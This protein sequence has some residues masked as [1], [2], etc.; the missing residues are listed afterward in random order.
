MQP[1]RHILAAVDGSES[2]LHAL[3]QAFKAPDCR[4]TAAAVVPPCRGTL[5]PRARICRPGSRLPTRKPWP[6][7]VTWPLP[8]AFP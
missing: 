7:A 1:Y 2:S 8:G 3:E 4:I 6:A 5:N